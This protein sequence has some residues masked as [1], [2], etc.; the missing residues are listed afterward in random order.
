VAAQQLRPYQADG[1]RRI[2]DAFKS[3]AR[4]VLCVSPCGSGKTTL[5][6]HLSAQLNAAGKNTLINVHRRELATQAANRLK[7]FDVPFGYIMSG[8]PTKPYAR[9]QVASVQTLVRRRMPVADLV[10]NDEA[11][12]ST[13][14]TWRTILD[15]YPAARILGTTA[16]PFR[17][18]GAP[19]ADAYDVVV[20]VTTPNELRERGDLCAYL[21]FSYKT[22]DLSEVKTVAGEFN[23]KQSAEAMR[24]PA[25]VA[26]IVEMWLK[27]ASE[28]STVVFAVTVE[29]SKELTAQFKTAGVA[30]EHLDGKT[31]LEQRKAILR[32]VESGETRVLCNVGVAV[33]GLDIPRLKCCVLARPTLSLSRYLQMVGR[34]R[35]PWGNQFARIHD[36]S[37]C[38]ARHGLPDADRDYSL[39]AKPEEPPNVTRCEEC[40]AMYQGPKCPACF[41]E[42]E[43][44]PA[45]ERVLATVADAEKFEFASGDEA[46]PEPRNEKPV[47]VRWDSIG[48]VI[49]G[50]FTKRWDEKTAWGTQ[51]RYLLRGDKRD[52]SIPGTTRLNALMAK[53]AIGDSLVVTH[54]ETTPIGGGK[55]RKEFKLEVDDGKPEV[56]PKV[57]AVRL[58]VEE[59]KTR[60]EICEIVGV[61]NADT[62]TAWLKKAGVE[63]RTGRFDTTDDIDSKKSE[64]IRRYQGGESMA[65]IASDLGL[66]TWVTVR[67]WLI[68]AGVPIRSK[69][70][71]QLL[72]QAREAST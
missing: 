67:N 32:R 19:L 62:I 70:E 17:L 3:G 1:L 18:S 53:V 31:S 30:A 44:E 2:L 71:A 58:Y 48:R 55:E 61:K 42:N 52:Y 41:H 9:V 14:K 22:P 43:V 69:S 16:T 10:V 51:R 50:I 47:E 57:E 15:S 59:K 29:H 65:P 6:T 27:H 39:N 12:L 34:V 11:H 66:K 23:E 36:H 7:E 24:A 35:R 20:V 5:F 26:N 28:L 40:G 60:Q 56:D 21:G 63:L 38:V 45:G 49:R 13:A 8:E 33:E 37:F 46:A 4:R 68:G 72:R 54:T 25:I 64:A